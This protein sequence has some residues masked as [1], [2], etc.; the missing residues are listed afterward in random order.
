MNI[1]KRNRHGT[2]SKAKV[3]Y[4]GRSQAVES[5]CIPL[6]NGRGLRPPR[7]AERRPDLSESPAKT[8]KEIFAA[9]DE[10]GVPT[11]SWLIENETPQ[12]RI[13]DGSNLDA[14]HK[15]SELHRPGTS[16]AQDRLD[17]LKINDV[18]CISSLPSGDSLWLARKPPSLAFRT[19]LNDFLERYKFCL[20]YDEAQAYE[21]SV[22]TGTAGKTLA[23]WIC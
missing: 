21:P 10:A 20:E 1:A 9:L 13:S 8:W 17:S 3:F 23:P 12:K 16:P 6:Y 18:G 22:Q 5:G 7:S 19:I 14:R 2:N 11:I 15:Y 4:S